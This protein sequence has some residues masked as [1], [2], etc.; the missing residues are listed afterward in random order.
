M[1]FAEGGD[2]SLVGTAT[3]MWG[4]EGGEKGMFSFFSQS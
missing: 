1:A 3:G 4:K 2:P